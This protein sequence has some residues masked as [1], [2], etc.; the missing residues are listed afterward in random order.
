[1]L[2]YITIYYSN[3]LVKVLVGHGGVEGRGS[4]TVGRIDPGSAVDQE[5]DD[6]EGGEQ[7]AGR[8]TSLVV[9]DVLSLQAEQKFLNIFSG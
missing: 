2:Y 5:G 7:V 3:L 8:H 9:E 6:L 4:V 1:M